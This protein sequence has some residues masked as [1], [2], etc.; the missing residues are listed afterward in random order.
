MSKLYIFGIGGT[1]SRV[2]RSLTMMLASGVELGSGI[3]SV[4][5]IIIDPDMSNADLTHTDGLIHSYKKISD[6]LKH[7]RSQG[8]CFFDTKIESITPQGDNILDMGELRGEEFRDFILLNKLNY[9]NE[10]LIRM[11]FS[12]KNLQSDMS[13][14]FK[15]NP[16]IGSVVLNKIVESPLFQAFANDFTDPENKIFI[17]SSIFGG[18]GASGFPILLK[19][20]RN[21]SN[22]PNNSCINNAHIGAVSILPYFTVKQNNKGVNEIEGDS[23]IS[24]TKSA[25]A[26]YEN[27]I[28][29]VDD[30]YFLSDISKASY[31]YSVGGS[32]QKNTAHLIELLA[33][34]A[35]VDFTYREL[36][37]IKDYSQR[38]ARYYEFGVNND[39]EPG[40]DINITHFYKDKNFDRIFVPMVQLSLVKKLF[41]DK[42]D[43]MQKHMQ[44]TFD[45]RE[46][47]KSDAMEELK[48]FIDEYK[49]W[50]D[51]MSSNTRALQ[52]FNFDE[53]NPFSIVSPSA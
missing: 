26:Y 44:S 27:N 5:P 21:L 14:G 43:Y 13:V 40:R 45:N 11:L 33:A 8:H 25:L 32:K 4:I 53:K 24:K 37:N 52:L 51:E 49:L 10:A 20:L 6:E 3:D 42:I 22:I 38:K 28:D 34:S 39:K 18:T 35:I 46:I 2:L 48:S 16:N 23:F 1:G 29:S 15:G 47:Y 17:I 7:G 50:L 41:D 9:E 19:N 31:E 12:E 30:L 36:H